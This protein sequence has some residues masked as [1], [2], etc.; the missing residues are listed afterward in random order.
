MELSGVI[1]PSLSSELDSSAFMI[2]GVWS[3]FPLIWTP[4]GPVPMSSI[5]GFKGGLRARDSL[6]AYRLG[7]S[8]SYSL[9]G[10]VLEVDLLRCSCL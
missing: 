7:A 9:V 6:G 1:E 8:A 10:G 2:I 5:V 3:G 4:S